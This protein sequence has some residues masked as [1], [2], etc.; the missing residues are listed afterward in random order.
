MRCP[1]PCGKVIYSTETTAQLMCIKTALAG[2]PSLTWY[3]EPR[4]GKW[5]VTNNTK[6]GRTGKRHKK[7]ESFCGGTEHAQQGHDDERAA[8][9][10]PCAA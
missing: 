7:M 4:C 9:H 1:E 6:H 10:E 2:D 5:H 8:G 3:R